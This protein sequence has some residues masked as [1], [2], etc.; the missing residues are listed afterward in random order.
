MNK[1]EVVAKAIDCCAEFL[2]SECPFHCYDDDVYTF[3]CIH[4]LMIAIKEVK[5][6]LQKSDCC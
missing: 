4:H 5:D 3:R 6:E 2:C 1:K